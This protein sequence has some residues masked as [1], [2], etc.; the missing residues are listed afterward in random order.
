MLFNRHFNLANK[1]ALLSPSKSAW[2]NYDDEKIDELLEKQMTAE[3]G[4]ELHEFAAKAIRLGVK[5]PDNGQTLSLYVNDCIGYRMTVEQ[6][7]YYSDNC[8]GAADAISFRRNVLR[9]FDLKNGVRM[10]SPRQLKVY[11]ALFCL[12]YLVKPHDIEIELRIYQSDEVRVYEVDPDEIAD[13]MS[14]IVAF[15]KRITARKAEEAS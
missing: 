15:D 11:S 2:V 4:T 7:L 5:L 13:I 8:F 12:E 6:S 3:L 9:I 10:T 14:K 1:H